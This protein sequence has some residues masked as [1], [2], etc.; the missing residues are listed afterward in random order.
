MPNDPAQKRFFKTNILVQPF[1]FEPFEPQYLLPLRLQFFDGRGTFKG[2]CLVAFN[3][4]H[5][6]I[7]C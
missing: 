3:P 6:R 1:A 5:R 4:A 2:L 7:A